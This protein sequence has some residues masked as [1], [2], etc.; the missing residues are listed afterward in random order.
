MKKTF[1]ILIVLGSFMSFSSCEKFLEV[2]LPVDKLAT[3]SVF[4]SKSTIEATVIGLY[5]GFGGLGLSLDYI[6]TNFLSDEIYYP[7]VAGG[8][9]NLAVA[10]IT[11]DE[12]LVN[13]WAH[14]YTTI[15]WANIVIENLPGV[16]SD[17]LTTEERDRYMGEAKYIRAACYW[18]MVNFWGDVPLILTSG[19]E[20]NQDMPRTPVSQVYD[21]II[22][23]LEE[24]VDLLPAA[25]SSDPT[26]I[27]NRYQAEALLARVYLYNGLWSQ[28]ET[29]ANNVITQNGYYQ[30]LPVLT[31]VF[32]RNSKE[33]L[34]STREIIQVS[35][36]L[37]KS[38][39]G[40]VFIADANHAMHPD[41]V[42]KFEAGDAR[43]TDWTTTVSG[44]VQPFKYFHSLF[45]DASS[46][47]QDFV[48]QRYAELFL[49][50]A[51][52][53]AQQNKLS[54]TDGAIADIDVIRS[55]AG[56]TG[57]PAV[58]QTEVLAAVEDERARELFNE[59]HRWFD[60][61]RT[62]KADLVLGALA[63]KSENYKP[64]MKF[65]PITPIQI[66]VNPALLQTE[67]YN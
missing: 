49:I 66:D 65:M 9:N 18:V 12:S 27:N 23:D 5:N 54:G 38:Y 3:E 25:V 28:A 17:I 30:L 8:R 1:I 39:Y 14:Y 55:R 7:T 43:V 41:F 34:F 21:Q 64:Y 47:P 10:S 61:K 6:S 29:A 15:H 52:A 60:L 67:G 19:L 42:A 24:A 35:F 4:K 51:E 36:Y 2:P 50:R 26:R 46:N 20:E 58:T 44:R 57:T 37:N 32:K 31:D 63:H 13:S 11:P 16:T 33:I 22:L 45:A 59:G 53:R 48:F 56:L 62:G 40:L